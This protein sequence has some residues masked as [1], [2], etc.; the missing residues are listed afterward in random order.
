MKSKLTTISIARKREAVIGGT[1]G[2]PMW[3]PSRAWTTQ[4]KENYI[5]LKEAELALMAS[6]RSDFLLIKN[7]ME[8]L[9]TLLQ[10]IHDR[11]I[12]YTAKIFDLN[13]D[14]LRLKQTL[15]ITIE[16]FEDECIARIPE[17]EAFGSGDTESVAIMELKREIANLYDDLI[18]S[19]I[20]EL[21]TLPTMWLRI[22]KTMIESK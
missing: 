11:P 8:Q 7:S 15:D 9:N 16:R 20:N 18:Q 19:D 2:Q 10:R 14:E 4:Q 6:L 22:L 5:P 17:L 13:N 12:A 3:S 21:G 1:L